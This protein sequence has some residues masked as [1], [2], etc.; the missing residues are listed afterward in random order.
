MSHHRCCCGQSQDPPCPGTA[1]FC[2]RAVASGI[3]FDP[4]C[5][6]RIAGRP[7]TITSLV[8]DGELN[9]ASNNPFTTAFIAWTDEV[10]GAYSG[11]DTIVRVRA[12]LGCRNNRPTIS[13][14]YIEPWG[15]GTHYGIPQVP[16]IFSW[17]VSSA[18]AR[19]IDIAQTLPNQ[20]ADAV[21]GPG[22]G[23]VICRSGHVVVQAVYDEA[24]DQNAPDMLL[25]GK[26]GDHSQTIVVDPNAGG[27]GARFLHNSELYEIIGRTTGTPASGVWVDTPCSSP[28]PAMLR[29]TGMISEADLEAMGFDPSREMRAAKQGGCCGQPSKEN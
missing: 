8:V 15:G 28:A 21:C 3:V 7:M 9:T 10:D 20:N 18:Q 14:F 19:F 24:C 29:T 2:L 6:E 26:C 22:G 17:R 23:G 25:A 27:S 12:A 1:G 16:S 5:P 11:T 4:A 13:E